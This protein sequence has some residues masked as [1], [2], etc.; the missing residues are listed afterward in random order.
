MPLEDLTSGRS[1]L[2]LIFMVRSGRLRPWPFCCKQLARG[3]DT[4]KLVEELPLGSNT[5]LEENALTLPDHA[6]DFDALESGVRSLQ[7]LETEHGTNSTFDGAVIR[8]E[9]V[10]E[11]FDLPVVHR[12]CE[13]V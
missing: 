7:R 13:H 10:V 12:S 1:I 11:V 4:E 9:L 5:G 6:H 3:V 2:T 8:F